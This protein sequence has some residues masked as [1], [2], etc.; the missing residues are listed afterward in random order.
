MARSSAGMSYRTQKK[1]TLGSHKVTARS[2]KSFRELSVHNISARSIRYNLH[3]QLTQT[4]S[5][6]PVFSAH[7]PAA[8]D[9]PFAPADVN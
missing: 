4:Q 8:E 2:F 6:L 5:L 7:A 3:E 1:D 9:L